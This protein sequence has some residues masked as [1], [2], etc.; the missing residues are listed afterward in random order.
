VKTVQEQFADRMLRVADGLLNDYFELPMMTVIGVLNETRRELRGPE[1][2]EPAAAQLT[3]LTRERLR[4]IA[5]EQAGPR[6][7]AC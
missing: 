5:N 4:V 6:A 7:F 1:G 3:A 2:E